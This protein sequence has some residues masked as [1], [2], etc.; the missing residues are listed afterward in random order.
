MLFMV[1]ETFRGG[2]PR[3]VYERARAQGRQLPDRLR[4]VD[5]WV[6]ADFGRCYQLMECDDLTLLMAWV[7]RWNDLVDFEIVPV[8]PSSQASPLL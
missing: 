8:V 4:Y 7:T 3:P 2:Q 1:I 5:S 6:A